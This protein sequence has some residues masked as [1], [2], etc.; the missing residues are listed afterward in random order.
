MSQVETQTSSVKRLIGNQQFLLLL[1]WFAMIGI[2]TAFNSI[3]FSTAVFGNILLDWAPVVLMA[4]GQT[5]VIVS[6]GIDLSVGSTVGL[7]GVVAAFQMQ[8]MMDNGD[9]Q[10]TIIIVGTLFAAAVGT[11]IGI[12]NGLLITRAK[13][14]P[15]IATLVTMGAGAGLELFIQ[16]EHL[17]Q[18][19]LTKPLNLVFL[20]LVHSL[21]QD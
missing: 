12:I 16:V 13:I 5:F 3:F 15:F 2:F 18:A 6:G 9:N 20:G 8:K 4:I 10:W 17:L 19:V 14:V 1:V 11:L 21:L 7:S